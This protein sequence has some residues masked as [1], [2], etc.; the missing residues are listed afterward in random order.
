[1]NAV[2]NLAYYQ[3]INLRVNDLNFGTLF[4]K[5]FTQPSG[6]ALLSR[7]LIMNTSLPHMAAFQVRLR[8]EPKRLLNKNLALSLVSLLLFGLLFS[9]S[10][11][12][13]SFGAP[14][15]LYMSAEQISRQLEELATASAS[16][17]GWTVSISPGVTIR[18]RTSGNVNFAIIHPYSIEIY[19]ILEGSGTLVTGGTLILP[20]A[21]S[22]SEDV[23][24]TEHGI[25]GGLARQ[26]SVG[27]VLVLQPGTPHWFSKIDGDSITYME[28]RITVSTH[29]IQFE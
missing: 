17:A 9:A 22:P 4:W 29:P 16:A 13:Q 19:R 21:E 6:L 20:L 8:A 2:G 25:D 11:S 18:Q 26:V 5:V 10:T 3:S 27:D 14:P 28:S 12:A 7:T 1:L 24:R 15:A 23:I